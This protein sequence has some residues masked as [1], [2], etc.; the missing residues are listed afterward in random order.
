MDDLHER[1][2]V[3]RHEIDNLKAALQTTEDNVEQHQLHARI[4]DCIRQS[5]QLID[6]HLGRHNAAAGAASADQEARQRS[7]GDNRS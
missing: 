5:I 1:F 7:V 4:N 2:L 6:Q 3:I